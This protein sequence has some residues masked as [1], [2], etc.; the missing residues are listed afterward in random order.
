MATRLEEFVLVLR[1]TNAGAVWH[2]DGR[3]LNASKIAPNVWHSRQKDFQA[4]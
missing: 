1:G 4:K 3:M 2:A